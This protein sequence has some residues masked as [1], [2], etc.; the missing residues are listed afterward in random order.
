MN[1]YV[2]GFMFNG[3]MSAVALIRKNKPDWQRG[4]LNG[5]GGKIEEGESDVSAMCRE[6][7]EECGAVTQPD[8][9]INYLTMGGKNDDGKPFEVCFYASRKDC[10]HSLESKTDEQVTVCAV[11]DVH[12]LRGDMIENLPWLI[13]LA[14]DNLKDGRP[15]FVEARY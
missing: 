4:K 2:A 10:L 6:F 12:P 11:E 3:E 7:W 8:E 15:H 14:I 1:R 9:W 13:A 5:I